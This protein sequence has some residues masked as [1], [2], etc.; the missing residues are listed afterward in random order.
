M[1]LWR[2]M[3]PALAAS[4]LLM[5]GCGATAGP[6][7]DRTAVV[8][9]PSAAPTSAPTP[10]TAPW[11][12]QVMAYPLGADTREMGLLS[13]VPPS[14]GADDGIRWPL[15]VYLNGYDS[16]GD[17]SEHDLRKLLTP[18][19]GISSMIAAGDW[20][21]HLPF[22]VLMPQYSLA[23]AQHC[24]LHDEIQ[25]VIDWA[26]RTYRVDAARVYLTGI[27]CGA[28]GAL[29]YLASSEARRVAAAVPIASAPVFA[30][31]K[32]GCGLAPTPMWFFHGELDEIVP[33]HFVR[34]VVAD[35]RACTDPPPAEIKL[36]IY[37]DANH[38]EW[39]RTYDGSAGHDVF[40]WMLEHTLP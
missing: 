35:L 4:A 18:G 31:E 7:A 1:T 21:T 14:Y 24:E 15:L 11:P 36:T 5:A 12:S 22:I 13:Y 17:G 33:V 6:S 10:S 30:W 8:A 20:P 40:A 27:S 37:P 28:I 39:M 38:D 23:D 26:E 16:N 25:S 19:W 32:A 34:D 2:P 29:D 9:T 3:L